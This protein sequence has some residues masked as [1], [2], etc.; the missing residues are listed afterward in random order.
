MKE[1]KPKKKSPSVLAVSPTLCC[2]STVQN[3]T[4]YRWH[5]GGAVLRYRGQRTRADKP[6]KNAQIRQSYILE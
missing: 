5:G 3:Y 1:K 2:P 4:I 6:H